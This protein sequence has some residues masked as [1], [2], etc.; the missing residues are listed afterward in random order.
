MEL[1]EYRR[2]VV[3]FPRECQGPGSSILQL[4]QFTSSTL[5]EAVEEGI[6]I[7]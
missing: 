4:L 5:R 2:N 3:I 6:A 7:V 1:S